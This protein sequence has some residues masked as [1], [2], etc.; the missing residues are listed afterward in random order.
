MTDS[1]V[2]VEETFESLIVMLVLGTKGL[3]ATIRSAFEPNEELSQAGEPGLLEL[4]LLGILSL[5]ERLDDVFGMPPAVSRT[6]RATPRSDED[7]LR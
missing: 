7:L 5:D 3:A 4:T 1:G 6:Q 2:R